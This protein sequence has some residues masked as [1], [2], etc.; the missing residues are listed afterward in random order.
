MENLQFIRERLHTEGLDYDTIHALLA[1]L[2]FIQFLFQRED[3]KGQTAISLE[4]L[5]KLHQEKTF[6]KPHKNLPDILSNYNDAYKFFRLLN[7]RFNG[8]LF[9]GNKEEAWQAEKAKVKK[10]H[11]QTLADFISG[12]FHQETGKGFLWHI[13]L[14]YYTA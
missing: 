2:I 7:D 12:K 6:S 10:E 3:S 11:L 4:Y 8:D 14:R 5:N 1:R 9:P 13:F